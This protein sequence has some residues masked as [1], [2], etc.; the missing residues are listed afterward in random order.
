MLA[1]NKY[2]KTRV[3]WR[4]SF[5]NDRHQNTIITLGPMIKSETS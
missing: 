4:H 2:M 3:E 5:I 1:T